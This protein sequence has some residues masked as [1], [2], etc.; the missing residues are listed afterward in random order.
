[1]ENKILKL[2]FPFKEK[3]GGKKVSTLFLIGTFNTESEIDIK[4]YTSEILK[5]YVKL[6]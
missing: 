6:W 1:M 3:L 4:N 5:S 2:L